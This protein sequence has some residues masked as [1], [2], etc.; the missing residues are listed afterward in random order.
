MP[1][2]SSAFPRALAHMAVL[3]LLLLVPLLVVLPAVLLVLQ[4]VLL[5]VLLAGERASGAWVWLRVLRRLRWRGPGARVC[6]P[7]GCRFGCTLR[8]IAQDNW[9]VGIGF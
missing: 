5:L 1:L 6:R 2:A 8:F 3:A 9:R 7:V 4:L